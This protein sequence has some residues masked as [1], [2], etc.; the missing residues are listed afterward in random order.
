MLGQAGDDRI[1]ASSLRADSIGFGA[2]GDDGDDQLSGGDGADSLNGG[3]GDDF[4]TGNGADDSVFTGDGDDI[5][6]WAPGDGSDI[7]SGEDG[8]DALRFS[9]S[10]ASEQFAIAADGF[11]GAT[12]TRDLD[13]V[14]MSLDRVETISVLSFGGADTLLVGDLSDFR[15]TGV[16]AIN[17]SFFDFGVPGG[18][19]DV[20]SVTGTESAD[21]FTVA[22]TAAT[23]S[24]RGLPVR[25]DLTGVEPSDRLEVNSLGGDD[26]VDSTGLAPNGMRFLAD[27]GDGSDTVLGGAGDDVLSGG[28]G[29]DVLFAGSGDNVVFGGAGDDVLRGEEG[30]DVL[31]GGDGDDV[32]IGGA[33]DDVLLNGEVVFDD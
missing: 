17:A 25:I 2:S 13:N 27:A 14:T 4:V 15:G 20:L 28:D 3:S 19:T 32:L 21:T 1:S 29:A 6:D 9:G 26:T 30:D 23:A 10:S 8:F 33:G 11:G 18:Q 24:V 22:G 31:D 7:A 12:L 16:E 5:I